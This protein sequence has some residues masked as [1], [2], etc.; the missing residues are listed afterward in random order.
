MFLTPLG[1]RVSHIY[2]VL[3]PLVRRRTR[4]EKRKGGIR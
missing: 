4:V 3:A 1:V 2:V